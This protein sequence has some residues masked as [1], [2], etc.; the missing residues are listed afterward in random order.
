MCHKETNERY[1]N[2]RCDEVCVAD[3]PTP[4]PASSPLP[5]ASTYFACTERKFSL[6]GRY[7]GAVSARPR[8]AAGWGKP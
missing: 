3:V 6:A 7:V 2:T 8:G 4:P 1:F 5:H